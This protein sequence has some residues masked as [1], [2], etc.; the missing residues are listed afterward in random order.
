MEN[1]QKSLSE[2]Q[3]QALEL[4]MSGKTDVEIARRVGVS[5]QWVNTWRNQDRIFMDALAERREEL[6]A[7][8]M[9]RICL[10]MDRAMYVLKLSGLQGFEC[11]NASHSSGV[12]PRCVVRPRTPLLWI[13]RQADEP[14]GAG[15]G[16]GA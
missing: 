1:D 8:Y 5:R 13:S 6:R 4:A 7:R 11:R 15:E 3:E 2:K 9:D 12:T 10:L 14:R 16:N